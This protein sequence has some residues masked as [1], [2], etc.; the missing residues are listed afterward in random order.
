MADVAKDLAAH[1]LM[2]EA[3]SIA[4]QETVLDDLF[5]RLVDQIIPK[6]REAVR[7]ELAARGGAA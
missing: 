5:K 7:R 6:L 2:M 3:A 1:V 4:R